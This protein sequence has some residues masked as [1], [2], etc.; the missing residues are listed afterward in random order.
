MRPASRRSPLPP[1]A[2][3]FTLEEP[4]KP[5]LFDADRGLPDEVTARYSVKTLVASLT[6]D[7]PAARKA[8][9]DFGRGAMGLTIELAD[10]KYQD[11]AGE[12]IEKVYLKTGISFPH[13]LQRYAELFLIAVRPLDRWNV[14]CATPDKLTIEVSGCAVFQAMKVKGLSYKELPCLELC[15]GGFRVAADKTG[16]KV[17]LDVPK[18]LPRDGRCQFVLAVA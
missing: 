9:A 6:P 13:R 8:C 10:S 12:M 14:T 7:L 4:G 1:P 15:L 5:L 18:T 2:A 3:P 16:D 11:R 17:R